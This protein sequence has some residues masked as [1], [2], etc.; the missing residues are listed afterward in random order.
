[1]SCL[2]FINTDFYISSIYCEENGCIGGKVSN[3]IYNS[4]CS[5][6]HQAWENIISFLSMKSQVCTI[7]TLFF[8]TVEAI[9]FL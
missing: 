2:V 7:S 6:D 5:T 4:I 9:I 3:Q 1:M 8:M